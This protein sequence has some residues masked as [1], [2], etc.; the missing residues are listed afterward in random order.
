ME[1]FASPLNCYHSRYC[2]AFYD[3][4]APFGSVGSFFEFKPD[5]GAYEANPP[6]VPEV[7]DAMA[8]H[9]EQLLGATKKP[10]MF[11]VIVPRWPDKIGWGRLNSGRYLRHHLV[12]P[13]KDHGYTEGSQ[14]TRDTRYRIATFD[15]SVFFLQNKASVQANPVSEAAVAAI[16]EGFKSKHLTEAEQR[17][18]G[19]EAVARSLY[20]GGTG[21]GLKKSKLR[22]LCEP[23]GALESVKIDKD[24][25]C[26]FVNFETADDCV[27]A[28]DSLQGTVREAVGPSCYVQFGKSRLLGENDG[29][30][31]KRK[32]A[33]AAAVEAT[34]GDGVA[35]V[36]SGTVKKAKRQIAETFNLRER[37]NPTVNSLEG[38]SLYKDAVTP[39]SERDLISFVEKN[40]KLGRK[41]SLPGETFFRGLKTITGNGREV[42]QYG[43][44][45][46]FQ[47][48]MIEPETIV[49]PIPPILEQLIDRLTSLGALPRSCRPDTVIINVYNQ[50]DCIPPHI[51]HPIYPRPFST[52]S[53]L[54]PASMLLGTYIKALGDGR[55][56]APFD[57]ELEPRSLLVFAGNGADISKHCVPPVKSRRISITMRRM[58]D[59]ARPICRKRFVIMERGAT[60]EEL[61]ELK[62][63]TAL[64]LGDQAAV[65]EKANQRQRISNRGSEGAARGSS[66]KHKSWKKEGDAVVAGAGLKKSLEP[67]SGPEKVIKKKKIGDGGEKGFVKKKKNDNDGDGGAPQPQGLKKKKGKGASGGEDMAWAR[68]QGFLL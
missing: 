43:A 21:P 63:E 52:L 28:L 51:D 39:E 22:A 48:H 11:V 1:C 13:Q 53:L 29:G 18:A 40:I 44:K 33:D 12:I 68:A 8:D 4:D 5:Q 25:Q 16:K 38:L 57:L 45:Y 2:S 10:L 17:V 64:A 67:P 54:S 65:W 41:K 23:F 66:L 49:E 61:E 15:T 58:P 36:T 31:L 46:N 42:L 47:K 56:K 7:I 55:F 9:M 3:T 62:E 26:G 59:F 19:G 6:F 34:I 30:L 37:G 35:N 32:I 24:K 20:F 50:G 27:E 14:H 60:S